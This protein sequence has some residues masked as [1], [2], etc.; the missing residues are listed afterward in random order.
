MIAFIDSFRFMSASLSNLVSNLSESF[1]NNTFIDCK[2]CLE[3]MK[4]KDEQLIFK[5]SSCKK[6]TKK[7][8]TKN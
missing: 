6:N 2:S 4:T 5:C 3:Y 8:L 7:T 1:H